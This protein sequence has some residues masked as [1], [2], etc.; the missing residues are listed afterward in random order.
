M[1]NKKEVGLSPMMEHYKQLKE[2]YS[3]AI[4]MYR[5]GDFY[6]MFFE[7]AKTASKVLDLTLT[8]RDCGLEERAPMCGVPIHAVDNYISRLVSAGYKVAICEQLSYPGDQKGLVKRDVIRVITAGTNVDDENADTSVNHYLAGVAEYSDAYS[9]ALIDVNTGE[10][11]VK[12]FAEHDF[13]LVEDYL[14][15]NAPSE[16]IACA[17][18]C[19][20]SR[21]LP[22][23]SGERLVKFSKYYDYAFDFDG[24]TKTL[25]KQYNV[26]ALDAIDLNRD[27]AAVCIGTYD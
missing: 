18:I 20:L 24:A 11:T 21:T 10:F 5:L 1:A 9:V 3:D 15:S 12:V 16:I 27:P 14:L 7:D 6:E 25:L 17:E 2:K 23:V 13:S 19:D 26:Y 22:S 4:L 8:G